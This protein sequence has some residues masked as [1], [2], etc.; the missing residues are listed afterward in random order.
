MRRNQ[1]AFLSLGRGQGLH[2]S[3][4]VSDKGPT[5]GST[6]S[7][8][9]NLEDLCFLCVSFQSLVLVQEHGEIFGQGSVG[10]MHAFIIPF[11]RPGAY[12]KEVVAPQAKYLNDHRSLKDIVKIRA[13][14]KTNTCCC[15]SFFCFWQVYSSRHRKS[16]GYGFGTSAK[17]V[18]DQSM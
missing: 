13:F 5:S 6:S 12:G 9:R 16:P 8:V 1:N 7:W 10:V 4:K 3:G 17:Q 2:G 18:Q 15:T 14:S 11:V